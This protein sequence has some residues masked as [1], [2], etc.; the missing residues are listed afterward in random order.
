MRARPAQSCARNASLVFGGEIGSCSVAT[1]PLRCLN[2]P[3]C[4]AH[5]LL[6]SASAECRSPERGRPGEARNVLKNSFVSA[7]DA[8]IDCAGACGAS[9]GRATVQQ[10]DLRVAQQHLETA[11]VRARRTGR[12]RMVADALQALAH[13]GH[14][15]GGL[16][17][18][19]QRAEEA[20]RLVLGIVVSTALGVDL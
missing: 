7:A 3:W 16:T 9:Y 10:G 5:V 17:E 1:R 6:D 14:D 11:L 8:P 20:R 4:L 15:L 13:A 12:H 18:P 2:R 19:L